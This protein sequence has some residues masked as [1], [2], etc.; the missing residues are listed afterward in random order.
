MKKYVFPGVVALMA[1]TNAFAADLPRKAVPPIAPVVLPTFSWTGFYFGV[2]AGAGFSD[3]V[4][5]TTT[6]NSDNITNDQLR[7]VGL[8]SVKYKSNGFAG[9]GQVGYNYQVTPGSGLVVG[10]EADID[11]VG[12]KRSKHWTKNFT[13]VFTNGTLVQRADLNARDGLD[14][15]GTVR[16]RVGFAFDRVL[17]YGTGGLAYGSTSYRHSLTLTNTY[18]PTGAASATD[19][20]TFGAQKSGTQ[21]GYAFGGGVE[22]ALP[23]DSFLNLLRSNAVTI[24]AE[25]LRYDLGSRSAVQ[26]DSTGKVPWSTTKIRSEGNVVRAGLNFKFGL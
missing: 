25:Y 22:Y 20:E 6:L 18:T 23:A 16:G 5:K 26:Y 2:N 11:Y 8:D 19:V 1:A 24:K 10:V 4:G 17:V 3:D 15:L 9:G 14:F 21:T 12:L 13:N 7:S